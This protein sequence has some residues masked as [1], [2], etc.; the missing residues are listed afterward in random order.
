M[1]LSKEEDTPMSN[2]NDIDA[3]IKGKAVGQCKLTIEV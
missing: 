2:S 1:G 3:D